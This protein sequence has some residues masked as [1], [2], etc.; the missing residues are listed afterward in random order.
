MPGT[1]PNTGEMSGRVDLARCCSSWQRAGWGKTWWTSAVRGRS[2]TVEAMADT[3]APLSS[4]AALRNALER[5]P[6]GT[7][8]VRLMTRLGLWSA[9]AHRSPGERKSFPARFSNLQPD[10]LSDLSARIIADAGRVLELCGLLNGIEAQLKM[11]AK[12]ARAAARSRARRE[13]SADVKAPTRA[14]LDDLAEEDPAV[15][16]VDEQIALLALLL[17]Q[18]TAVR[19]ANQMYKE[20]VSREI[21]YRGAQMSARL[22]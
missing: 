15:V 5:L 19:E 2:G 1:G 6:N 9:E 20:G 22:I 3:D 12:A 8:A 14:E 7:E 4:I 17:A 18:A 11:R 10:D 21:T 13:W 16:A